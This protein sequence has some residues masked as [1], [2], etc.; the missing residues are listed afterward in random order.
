[1]RTTLGVMAAMLALPAASFGLSAGLG[2]QWAD[3]VGPAQPLNE[4]DSLGNT[5]IT[6]TLSTDENLAGVQYSILATYDADGD[7]AGVAVDASDKFAFTATIALSGKGANP[8]AGPAKL[9]AYEDMGVFDSSGFDD[10]IFGKGD[11]IPGFNAAPTTFA[12]ANPEVVFR[13]TGET[14]AIYVAPAEAAQNKLITYQIA[15]TMGLAAGTYEIT[16]GD[17]AG[18][19]FSA[20]NDASGC[21]TPSAGLLR[22]IVV[23]EPAS[24]LLLLAAVPF[25]RRRR[26]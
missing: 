18:L 26:A 17:K 24:A 10:T 21:V 16:V 2:L 19:G 11:Y 14:Q 6:V 8:F 3:G 4:G 23:P 12:A 15:S 7:G 20:C 25:L 22:L 9:H 1:M 13:N 5:G